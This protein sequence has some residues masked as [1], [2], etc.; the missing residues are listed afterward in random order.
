MTDSKPLSK[1]LIDL[2]YQNSWPDNT[3]EIVKNCR[4]PAEYYRTEYGC[5]REVRCVICGYK[6]KIDSGD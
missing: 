6:Y 2:G 3:P 5:V 4:H 1:P